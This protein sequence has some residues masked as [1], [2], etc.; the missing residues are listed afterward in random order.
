MPDIYALHKYQA[1]GNDFIILDG[2]GIL[3]FSPFSAESIARLCHRKFGIGADGFI[4]ARP[5]EGGKAEML[6]WN[7][8]GNRS[9]LCGNGLRA[10]ALFCTQ[11]IGLGPEVELL[12]ADGW[13]KVQ[14]IAENYLEAEMAD[15][16]AIESRQKD[17]VL[18]TG[19][20]HFVR[21]V[22]GVDS[23][24]VDA[25]GRAIR[26]WP[27][28]EAEGINVNFAAE[29]APGTIRI[30]T[31]ERGVEAE[32]LSCGTGVT[33]AAIAYCTMKGRVGRQTIKVLAEGGQLGVTFN[34]NADGS[35]TAVT[36]A[37]P[38]CHV[39]S[40]QFPL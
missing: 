40:T 18:N 23:L 15:V 3:D 19:S 10:T 34:L 39:F 7:S 36:L 11:H 22:N 33:A 25:E 9:S 6:Y 2:T 12:A 14:K 17:Y 26:H 13:H 30:R 24:D 32:T 28:F 4:I 20:P 29:A 21:F 5:L 37:G 31:Y 1:A 16:L 35:A 27:E 8:D 38:A